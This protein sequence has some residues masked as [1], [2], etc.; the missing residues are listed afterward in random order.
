MAAIFTNDWI[1]FIEQLL[2]RNVGSLPVASKYYLCASASTTLARAST[3]ADFI[4][5]ELK[6]EYGYDRANVLWPSNG[7]YSNVNQRHD[8][9]TV[10]TTWTATGGTLQ[11]QSVFLLANAH[12]KASESFSPTNVSGSTATIAGNLLINGDTVIPVADAGSTL[13]GNLVNNTAYTVLNVN[14]GTGAF[15]FSSDGINPIAL[16][17]AGS[18]TFRLK[19]ASG[20]AVLLQIEPSVVSVESGRPVQY[21]IDIAGMNTTYGAGI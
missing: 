19:Y 3:V 11:F 2:Y 5:A 10:T 6:P 18:G 20:L 7:T 15:Q 17:N 14:S 16:S 21:D 1:S 9:P 4:R 13:P 12:S 8:L